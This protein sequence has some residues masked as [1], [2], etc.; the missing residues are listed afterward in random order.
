MA[1]KEQIIILSGK[2]G[3]EKVKHLL[4]DILKNQLGAKDDEIDLEENLLTCRGRIDALWGRTVFEVKRNLQKEL[5]DAENQL[6][7]YIQSKEK[8]TGE[9]YVGIATDGQKYRVYSLL[10]NSLKEISQFTLSKDK[11]S[12]FIQWL[13][14]VILIKD[15]LEATP[16]IICKEIGQGSPLCRNSIMQI[17]LLWEQ[18]K[19][20]PDIKLK[21]NL[22]K[23]SVDIVYGMEGADE[24]LFI[25]HTYLTIIS[26]AIAYISFFDDRKVLSGEDLLN[27]KSFDEA[28]VFGVVED[29]FFSW[30]V[31]FEKGNNLI[32]Q[33]ASHIERFD[34]ST[35]EADILKGLYEGLIRQE[36]RHKLG[37]YYTPD[38]L[39]EKVCR[40]TIKKP[41][42]Y[43]VIDPS[44]GSGTFL[45]HSIKLLIEKA[46]RSGIS[47]KEIIGL[48]CEKI[49]G[50]DIHPVAV[51]FSRITYL[52]AMLEEIKKDRPD[53]VIVPVYL[54]D[55]LQWSKDDILGQYNLRI[56]VPEDK[57]TGAKR[58]ELLFPQSICK[59]SDKFDKVLSKMIELAGQHKDQ[60]MFQAWLGK[61]SNDEDEYNILSET[62]KD[63]LELQKEDRNHI[64]GY[65]AR[66][67]TR[68]IWL[69]SETQKADVVIGN[70]PWL[71]FNSMN[72]KMQ[73]KFKDECKATLL[74]DTTTNS[75]NLQTSQ[76]ISTY[77]FIMS[78][79][80]YMREKGTL[81]F[82]MPYGI[83]NGEHHS[84][85]RTGHFQI[86]GNDMYIKF[87]KVWAFDSQVKN[88]FKIPSCVFF[89]ERKKL[90][91]KSMT[92]KIIAFKGSLPQKNSSLKE[93]DAVLSL[94]YKNWTVNDYE[95]YSYY[96]DKFKQGASLVPRRFNFVEEIQRGQLGSSSTT[97]L[98]KGIIS[99][100]DKTP[101][102]SIEP[103][104]AKIE[105]QFLRPVYT[106]QSIAPFR[107]L[108]LNT[109]VI[110]WDNKNGVM[111]AGEAEL[112]G[113]TYLGNYLEK[114]ETLWNKNS[115]GK[116]TFK[117]RINYQNLLENQFPISKLRIAYTASG[118]K[119][120]AVLLEDSQ[121]I[122]DTKL[123]WFNVS[124]RNEGTYLEGILNSDFLIK[125]I[126]DLQS[127]GQWGRR[128]IHRHLLKPPIPKYDSKNK[129]HKDIIHY[130]KQ[131]RK[132]AQDVEIESSWYF[133]KSRKKIRDE[134]KNKKEWHKLNDLICRLLESPVEEAKKQ[135][136]RIQ[137]ARKRVPKGEKAKKTKSGRDKP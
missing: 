28:N 131:I 76:D 85:F 35:I 95:R 4:C 86:V 9:K 96:Y 90:E 30:I 126:A 15:Q 117:E 63:L 7:R 81:A 61:Q 133:I 99:N 120:A 74:W 43:R 93:A 121:G 71:K 65:V 32:K 41:L 25:E 1:L 136:K 97:P 49:A 114:V 33:I 10:K 57:N 78:A 122:V 89:S 21:Y 108:K 13:E 3:H 19:S 16:E 58:R 36:Q 5:I 110:P 42:D 17:D 119:V 24:S 72:Q 91:E 59:N 130:T 62:Y 98:V 38:W 92:N 60:S 52:L 56:E 102:N 132:I 82:V 45:F 124:D 18:A 113:F 111:N 73:T 54:G 27:G 50:I 8:E 29:D 128:D 125:T 87:K 44:C 39:A 135:K 37:E 83:I 101:W 109:G 134:I 106:G 51:I 88:L 118:T 116:M 79:H 70:P 26:K 20:K 80:L 75:S 14:S 12:E 66:N 68:P 94:E 46:K 105:S 137:K 69:S 6:R 129:L 22:W 31:S 77:F 48:I 104:E 64:W 127:Q 100:Q 67:L 11:A 115:S 112:N 47:S 103:L 123:Y 84:S 107:V 34:F 23:K 53:D 55:S 40:E 2:P